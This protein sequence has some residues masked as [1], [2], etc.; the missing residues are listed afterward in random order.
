MTLDSNRKRCALSSEYSE[1][2]DAITLSDL[3]HQLSHDI[4]NPL[5]SI[6]SYSSIMEQAENFSLP[7]TK[8]SDY[9]KSISKETWRISILLE[10]FLLLTSQRGDKNRV[11]LPDLKQKILSRYEARYQLGEMDIFFEGFEGDVAVVADIEQCSAILCE[12]LSN[13]L[14]AQK[15]LIEATSN[16]KTVGNSGSEEDLQLSLSFNVIQEDNYLIL[17]SKN[18]T[19][20]HTK[21]LN[22]LL[23]IGEKE[24]PSGK[25][26]LGIGLSAISSAMKRWEGFLSLE[27]VEDQEACIFITRLYFPSE[28]KENP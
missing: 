13:A 4:G 21:D 17:E 19:P 28:K 12:I 25:D 27:E 26:N 9:S 14:A 20:R 11:S 22:Q 10:K 23:K 5:T 6:I 8:V 18:K 1:K 24:F 16:I 2:I 3:V 7:L 15:R